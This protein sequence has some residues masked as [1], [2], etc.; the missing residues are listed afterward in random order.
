MKKLA[1]YLL[2]ILLALAV[3]LVKYCK[4]SATVNKPSKKQTVVAA[5]DV[6]QP[7]GLNRHPSH[8]NYSKHAQ[9]RM[10]CRHIDASEVQDILENGTINYKKSELQGEDCRK[11]YAVEGYSKDKQ[12]LRVIFAPCADEITVVTCIDIGAEWACDCK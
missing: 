3:L 12:H 11:K 10:G 4:Q 2:L 6:K 1:P 5:P 9:C 8:I 7:R